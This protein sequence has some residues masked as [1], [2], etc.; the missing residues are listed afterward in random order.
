[1]IYNLDSL[2]SEVERWHMEP[3]V[4]LS[5]EDVRQILVVLRHVKIRDDHD[6]KECS[7]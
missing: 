7:T 3:G 4:F 2:I 1:M 6:E 5:K